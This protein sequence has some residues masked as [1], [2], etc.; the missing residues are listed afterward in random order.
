MTISISSRP[1]SDEITPKVTVSEV[2]SGRLLR[3]TFANG[4]A[5]AWSA[6]VTVV[7]TPFLLHRFGSEQ[8]GLWVLALGLTFSSGYLA[9]AD[10]GLTEA[11]VKFIAEARASGSAAAISAIA[12][13][14]L[15]VFS[16]VGVLVG[17]AMW[18]LAP[19]FVD[20]FGVSEHLAA[21]AR[22]LFALMALEILV[23]LPTTALRAVI[24]GIQEYV[25]LRSIDVI[26]RTLWAVLVVVAVFRG[27]GV[28]ALGVITLIAAAVRSLATLVVAYR[29]APGLR[30]RPRLVT[31]SVLRATLGFGS[32]VG[33]L[34]VLTVI[35]AQ[36][37]RVIIAVAI[38]VA[39]VAGYEVV[40]RIQ[41]LT[42][43]ALVMAS[44]AVVPAAAYNA[45]RGDHERQRELYLRGTKYAMAISLPVCIAAL[46]YAR[47]LIVS[48]VGAKYASET[49]AARIFLLFPI[50]A[51]VNQVGVAMLIGLG[52]V[53]RVL[54]L[55]VIAVGVNLILS[56][57]LAGPLGITGVVIGTCVG[58]LVVWLPYLHTLLT[59]FAV[60][61]RDWWSRAIRPNLPGA[62]VQVSVGLLTLAWCSNV[63]S[64]WLV[65]MLFTAS[66]AL[67]A[68]TFIFLGMDFTEREH[69]WSRVK[70][71][72]VGASGQDGEG[73]AESPRNNERISAT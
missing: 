13:T 49:A 52:R 39:A 65:G 51:S 71:G 35:Y 24:E 17:G 45:T 63:D 56:I 64:F 29:V 70:R 11:A 73:G 12:S 36:M 4:T 40:F 32:L 28:V 15:A 59:T 50:F 9:L 46:L 25:W 37:D 34:R 53:R 61:V 16:V 69:L 31:R 7:L 55:Q 62:V 20:W 30:L 6:L 42:T 43:L 10:F 41:S 54:L 23:E 48:W 60:P 5:S 18:A 14:T 38:S 21:T 1:P 27:H 22:V 66:C 33:G 8:Y 19:R 44:S 67:N 26:G 47:L 72:S 57:A 3:N 58:G 68:A 2:T